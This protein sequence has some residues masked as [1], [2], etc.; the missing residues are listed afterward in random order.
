[1]TVAVTT[2]LESLSPFARAVFEHNPGRFHAALWAPADR[3]AGL[4]AIYALDAELS[5]QIA[6]AAEPALVEI[7]LRWWADTFENPKPGIVRGVPLLDTLSRMDSDCGGLGKM[8]LQV[9]EACEIPEDRDSTGPFPEGHPG[10]GQPP[11]EPA[12]GAPQDHEARAQ[13]VGRAAAFWLGADHDD[14]LE[15]AGDAD[16]AWALA[17]AARQAH[18]DERDSLKR[19]AQ[20]S[21][22]R[23]RQIRSRVV[24]AWRAP[25]L[26]ATRADLLLR[27]LDKQGSEADLPPVPDPTTRSPALRLLWATLSGFY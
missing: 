6:R 23:A 3:R 14:V 5:R 17:M 7:R 18:G 25:F 2:N 16:C 20:T 12:S 1:M 27:H 8:L 4:L 9:C 19:A 10:A 13:A 26:L 24:R 21:V 15:A 22:T 11:E